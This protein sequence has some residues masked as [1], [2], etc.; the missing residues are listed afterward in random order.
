MQSS[1]EIINARSNR[2]IDNKY[3][4]SN[5]SNRLIEK[6]LVDNSDIIDSQWVD[7]HAKYCYTFGVDRYVELVRIARLKSNTP[8]RLLAYLVNKEMQSCNRH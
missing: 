8:T 2:L 4:T 1:Q 7:R 6:T 3:I 5:R